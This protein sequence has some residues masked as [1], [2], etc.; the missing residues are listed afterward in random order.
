MAY[1]T[2]GTKL[3]KP[4]WTS[5]TCLIALPVAL[6]P[7]RIYF[8]FFVIFYQLLRIRNKTNFEVSIEF[9]WISNDRTSRFMFDF[10]NRSGVLLFGHTQCL[11]WSIVES[12]C[13]NGGK[14][15][16]L[17][18]EVGRPTVVSDNVVI[19]FSS[20]EIFCTWIFSRV[21]ILSLTIAVVLLP[22]LLTWI[23]HH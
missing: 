4:K 7:P 20:Y 2:H 1:L 17:S 8:F 6:V 23:P 10:A 21:T 9:C 14:F 19:R 13:I 5:L 16:L 22:H 11:C 12:A 15:M 3:V 18:G